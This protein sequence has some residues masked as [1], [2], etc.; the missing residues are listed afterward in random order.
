MSRHFPSVKDLRR[1]S[2]QIFRK[3]EN[4]CVYE[5]VYMC[6]CVCMPACEQDKEKNMKNMITDNEERG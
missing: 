1:G 2:T 6:V 4:K 3:R 5:C